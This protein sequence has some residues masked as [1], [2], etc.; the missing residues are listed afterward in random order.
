MREPTPETRLRKAPKLWQ[1]V[2]EKPEQVLRQPPTRTLPGQANILPTGAKP[3]PVTP[4]VLPKVAE[5][6]PA[7]EKVIPAKAEQ[8]DLAPAKEPGPPAYQFKK[9][10]MVMAKPG[11]NVPSYLTGKMK[12]SSI[13]KEGLIR[14]E[15]D[16]LWF[17]PKKFSL[18][19]KAM[20]EDTP[21]PKVKTQRLTPQI[22]LGKAVEN[23]DRPTIIKAYGG[24]DS[25]S[26]ALRGLAPE[27]RRQLNISGL[28]RT[29]ARGGVAV[30]DL[31]HSLKE[32]YPAHFGEYA[33][34]LI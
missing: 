19:E 27:E 32:N 9:G 16:K 2:E 33:M 26:P 28:I 3:L 24:I 13:S 21:A 4:E 10:D 18:Q 31:L 11:S 7:P 5:P 29:K 22:D 20:G 14:L 25:Q 17:T 23:Y 12:I 30:D 15:G 6:L 1:A 8:P 34:S